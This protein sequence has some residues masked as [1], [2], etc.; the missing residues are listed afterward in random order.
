MSGLLPCWLKT[1]KQETKE[2]EK[3]LLSFFF[4]CF[5]LMCFIAHHRLKQSLV[6]LSLEQRLWAHTLTFTLSERKQKDE[7]EEVWKKGRC[8]VGKL[9]RK[10]KKLKPFVCANDGENKHRMH[11]QTPRSFWIVVN[12]RER[13][14]RG[15]MLH[16]SAVDVKQSS[17]L[18]L[19]WPF[20]GAR[21]LSS[22]NVLPN[23]KFSNLPVDLCVVLSG[24]YVGLLW[25]L[26]FIFISKTT[27]IMTL[28]NLFCSCFLDAY[29]F[30]IKA[31]FFTLRFGGL[32][33][34]WHLESDF[35]T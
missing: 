28:T 24:L 31:I 29:C 33:S 13:C 18:G 11:E 17:C 19:M 2:E 5:G 25:L 22:L 9:F 23:C 21:L 20:Q 6:R 34:C 27:M 3:D 10:K 14:S 35:V 1:K 8:D 26:S 7:D 16:L 12:S 32:C 30:F 15:S 4:F